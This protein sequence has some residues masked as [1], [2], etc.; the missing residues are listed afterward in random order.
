V[1]SFSLLTIPMILLGLGAALLLAPSCK[2]QSEVSPD[3]FDGTDPW[4]IA[5][6]TAVARNAKPT[7][8]TGSYQAQNR[9]AGSGANLQLAAIHDHD[10][11][12][13]SPRNPVALQEKRKIAARKSDQK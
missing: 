11:S 5:A 2:A 6:R 12:K 10:I 7:K 13:S 3:H 1:K 4:E 9:K 8:T